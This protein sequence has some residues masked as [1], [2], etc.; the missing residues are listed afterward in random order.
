MQ[1]ALSVLATVMPRKK[2]TENIGPAQ[3]PAG[4]DSSDSD[5]K[6]EVKLVKKKD[7]KGLPGDFW[8]QRAVVR[9]FKLVQLKHLKIAEACEKAGV[10]N[11]MKFYTVY[12]RFCIQTNRNPYLPVFI[13]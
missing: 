4:W 7:W 12:R 9:L 6:R 3:T 10:V 2:R 1:H 11:Y 5:D 13:K 8:L